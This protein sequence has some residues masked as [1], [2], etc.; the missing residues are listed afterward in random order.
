LRTLTEVKHI[1]SLS[2]IRLGQLVE[3]VSSNE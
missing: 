2:I 3:I 1:T